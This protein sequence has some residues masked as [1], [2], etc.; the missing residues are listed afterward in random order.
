MRQGIPFIV[1]GPSGGGKTTLAKSVLD[2]L[3]NLRFSVSYTTRK[4]RDGEVDGQDYRFISETEFSEMVSQGRFVEHAMVHGNFYGTPVDEFENAHVSGVDLLLDIDVQG[5]SQIKAKYPSAVF[6]F[7]FPPS[8]E[9]LK[10]RL[11]DRNRD[12]DGDSDIDKR[13][14][15]AKEEIEGLNSENYNYIIINDN[16]DEALECLSSIIVSARCK[17]KRILEKVKANFFS[18]IK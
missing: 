5:A 2:K 10:Q 15:R 17:S 6:C 8:F 4:P 12:S 18:R 13:L 14:I 3:G 9:V 1:S 16:L 7:V 11:I